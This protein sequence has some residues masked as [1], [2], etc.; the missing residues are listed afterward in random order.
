MASE[1][2][3]DLPV[4]PAAEAQA[5][6][7]SEAAAAPQKDA[8]AKTKQAPSP[9]VLPEVMI[10]R[11]NLFEELW[12]QH[13]EDTKTRPHPEISITLD[14]GD[15]NAPKP[16]PAKAYETTPG[17]FLRDVPKDLS[18]NIVIAKVDGELWDLNR[19]LEKDCQ[20]ALLPF[21]NPEA[22]EVFWHSS[23]HC[24]GEAC[25]CEY[26]CLLSHGPP[27]AQGFFYDMAMP[28]GRVVRESDWKALDT[29]ASRIFKEKQSFDR[30][31]VSKENLKKMFAYSKYK[32]HYIDKLVTGESST[33]Y[34]C[35]TLV[36]LCRGPHIQNTGKIKTFKIMQNS[37][38]YFLGDQTNDSL[39]RI[40]GV[41]FPDK[42]LM[43]E[44]LKFL[45]EAEKRNHLRIGKEQELFFFDEMSPGS[46]FL[47]PNGVKIFNQI[48]S[49]LRTE[50]RK[51][52]YQEVQTPNMF[53]VNLWKTSGHWQHYKDD[54]FAL[55]K[56]KDA[57]PSVKPTDKNAAQVAA[58]EKQFALKP[59]N[60]PGHF[61]LFNHRERSYREL[62]MR[63]ADFGVLHR[64]EASGALSG[65]TR[66]RR[67]Q[68]D[69]SHIIVTPD[70]IMSEVE[71]LF[72]FLRSIY[73]LFGFTFKLKLSTRPEKYMGSLDTWD[74]AEDQLKKALTKF[75]GNDWIIDEGDGAFYGPKIDI[76]IA[77]ALKRE[78]QCATIQLDYQAPINFKM[79]YMTNEQQATQDKPKE[80]EPKG[81]EP[82]P[83]RARPVV[84]HRAIIGSFERFLGILIEHFG[85]KWP[86]WLSP[87]QILIVPVM[88]AVNDYVEELQQ[89]LRGDKLNVDIDISGNTMQKKIRTGQLA[90][91]NFIFV[92]GAS[93]KESRTVNIRNRD[94]PA[95]QKQGTMVSVEDV[96]VQL[97]AL[98]KERRMENA[99]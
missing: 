48:Q 92:V 9:D 79:E 34:R 44:H 86:F 10:E 30:L 69:D 29:K 99:L 14:I 76:T 24:L 23:A 61:L 53:D 96:R 7:A 42:K 18:A 84:I 2:S 88:P 1:A 98:R 17:S 33:V 8:N 71:G 65:L 93:E 19:P 70:Q 78:F 74:H 46:P 26:G 12:Q 20:V 40:R 85:G 25:E 49:L 97:K 39:Q 54:M 11:N 81:D 6:N 67:F 4:R 55:A 82:G 47:L 16:V 50:Y 56:D 36:D 91:Y 35:G 22:R 77:D 60:C 80:G 28:D 41:A 89:L 83:G 15:G 58:A 59:M 21:S 57:E 43:A 87:R 72:D 73:G 95:S 31:E 37:S 64:N 27:T 90:Q 75:M 38:A 51:R 68:Q 45:E 3:K 94:D 62:P 32:L 5:N 63:L 13:L 66:V 52:G